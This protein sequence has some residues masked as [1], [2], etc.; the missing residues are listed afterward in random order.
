MS[1][2]PN[3]TSRTPLL[4]AHAS[5]Q[6]SSRS[7][8]GLSP[9]PQSRFRRTTSQFSPNRHRRRGRRRKSPPIHF[10]PALLV[11]TVLASVLFLAWDVSSYGKCYFSSLCRIIGSGE[12][13]DDVFFLNSG[14]YAPWRSGGQGGGKRG[15][16]RGCEINQVTLVSVCDPT[17]RATVL[18]EQCRIASHS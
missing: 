4:A 3:P 1:S 13:K 7:S 2:A 12:D 11:S 8:R 6:Q 15:L 5:A 14:A 10:V 16:P 9:D 17:C 18:A